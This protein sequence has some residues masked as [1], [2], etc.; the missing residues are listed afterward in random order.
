MLFI[1]VCITCGYLYINKSVKSYIK[2]FDH[3]QRVM[4]L[5]EC[6]M[7]TCFGT[8]RAPAK[9][10]A[11]HGRGVSTLCP[12]PGEAALPAVLESPGKTAGRKVR[13][14]NTVG[15]EGGVWVSN[16]NAKDSLTT[17]RCPAGCW[18]RH[19]AAGRGGTSP[20]APHLC[21]KLGFPCTHS[22][23]SHPPLGFAL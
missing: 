5:S 14:G 1:Q 23:S 3:P 22:V 18:I 12:C 4:W 21:R 8:K 16:L 6:V 2:G 11:A 10:Q 17:L 20:T 7:A 19:K 13:N 15:V 9:M